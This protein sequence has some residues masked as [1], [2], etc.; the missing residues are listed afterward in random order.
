MK[1]TTVATRIQ[2]ENFDTDFSSEV[3]MLEKCISQV[4][5]DEE[6]WES[7]FKRLKQYFVLHGTANDKKVSALLTF[8]GPKTCQ[9]LKDL[10]SP[11]KPSEKNYQ[12]MVE[13]L[14]KHLTPKGITIAERFKFSKRDQL[15][16]ESI[17]NYVAALRKLSATCNY[18]EFLDNAITEPFVC[19][20]KSR[21]I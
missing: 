3:T 12:Q 13:V 18:G 19:G 8:M 9:L 21:C 7:Y 2:Q 15:D 5:S 4:N 10:L 17:N 14:S 16:G 20:L 6:C 1:N 11:Q